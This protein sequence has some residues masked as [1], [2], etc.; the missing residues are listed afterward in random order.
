[1]TKIISTPNPALHIS[2]IFWWISGVVVAKG[3]WS[4]AIAVLFFP[5]SF[6]LAVEGLYQWLGSL[7]GFCS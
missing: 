6:Y 2:L 1:M 3:F 4:T 5:Y 7:P